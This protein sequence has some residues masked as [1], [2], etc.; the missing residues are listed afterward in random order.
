MGV[1][2]RQIRTVLCAAALILLLPGVPRGEERPGKAFLWKARSERGTAYLLGSIHYLR[3]EMYPLDPRIEAAYEESSAL[4]VETDILADG[5][6]G[7]TLFL[8][9]Q[10]VYPPDDGLDRHLSKDTM[11]RLRNAVGEAFL[12]VLLRFRPWAAAMTVSS[13]KLQE[14]GFDPRYGVDWHF[15]E[16]ARGRKRILELEPFEEQASL[17]S[18][19]SEPMQEQFL[20]YTLEELGT[21]REE[22]DRIVSAWNSGDAAEMEEIVSRTERDNPGLSPVLDLLLRT[23]NRSM[24]ERILR[25]LEREPS[26][27]VVVGA[28]HLVGEEGIV[29]RL[30]SR[31]ISVEQVEGS[32]A[33]R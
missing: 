30:R 24:T 21:A 23:R 15:L 27:F 8:L 14:M 1:G 20:R 18:S 2:G 7:A 17:L 5:G 19:L 25:L 31:G 6:Q 11:D 9:T 26:L 22:L 32:P 33:K 28:A 12:P 29:E 16:K 10:A 3:K 13:A 4:V